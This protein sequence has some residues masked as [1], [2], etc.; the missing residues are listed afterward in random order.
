MAKQSNAAA[1]QM[2][3]QEIQEFLI[4]HNKAARTL[5]ALAKPE[6][7]GDANRMVPFNDENR[8]SFLKIDKGANWVESFMKNL[9]SQFKD[10]THFNLFSI[11]EANLDD[12]K[13]KKALKDLAAGKETQA[14]KDFLGKYEIR[15]KA[16]AQEQSDGIDW[17]KFKEMGITKEGLKAMG[18]LDD[19]YKKHAAQVPAQAQ[20]TRY[21]EALAPWSELEAIGISREY[22]V[23]RNLLPDLLNGYKSKEVVP[24][25]IDTGFARARIEGKIAFVPG[26]DEGR[27]KFL[28]W[29]VKEKPSFDTPFM[30]HVFSVEDRRNLLET[31]NMGR[32]VSL[33]HRDNDFAESFISLD[34][35]TN[36]LFAVKASDVVIPREIQNVTLDEN[37]MNALREGKAIQ[38]E[39]TSAKKGREY[40]VTIQISADR[41]GIEYI[42]ENDGK[43]NAESLGGKE[44][45]QNERD[46]LNAGETV[47]V[48]GMINRTTGAPYDRFV[49]LDPGTGRPLY[50]SFNPDSPEDARQIIVPR[51]LGG[52][53]IP[54]VDRLD[55]QV[56]K[57]VHIPD[58]VSAKGEPLPPF[59]RLDMRT[60]KAQ[61]SYD[62]NKF[63]ER[64]AFNVPQNIHNVQ[65]SSLQR[66]QLQDGK[67]VKVDGIVTA[68]G[69]VITQYA[70]VS[71]NQ[72]HIVLTNDNPE[73]RRERSQS[74]RNFKKTQDNRQG[75]RQAV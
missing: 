25:T 44:L 21:N 65:L 72:T 1:E 10:P 64:P 2:T 71:K 56:G 43:F 69:K 16:T 24:M 59:V 45:T 42:F 48:E 4:L 50:F 58:M 53:Q 7:D 68:G 73:T 52:V 35:K 32:T 26:G 9:V 47:L 27:L 22:L 15:A 46:R 28:V 12:P 14:V 17:E 61:F 8:N 37:E 30:G 39:L 63:E 57:V 62:P 31:G 60:G 51:D 75:A 33:L 36:D 74:N 54:E 20:E 3:P 11:Q 41:R 55:L 66:A 34:R 40:P 29:G 19:F 23:K 6:K 70:Q 38:L 13:T 5:E 49:K 67:A 18:L